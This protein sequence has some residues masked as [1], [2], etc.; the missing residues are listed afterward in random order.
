MELS[1]E[2]FAGRGRGVKTGAS[3]LRGRVG[4]AIVIVRVRISWS[5]SFAKL[6]AW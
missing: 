4:G 5:F 3:G 2:G 1:V 6:C